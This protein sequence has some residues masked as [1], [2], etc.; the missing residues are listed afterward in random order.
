MTK[1]RKTRHKI[2]GETMENR[3]HHKQLSCKKK[4]D[5]SKNLRKFKNAATGKN[6][7]QEKIS[8]ITENLIPS[9]RTNQH[10]QLSI[11]P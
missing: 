4:E 11:A 2:L 6:S 10:R 1:G 7:L 8:S 3:H 9:E 5:N